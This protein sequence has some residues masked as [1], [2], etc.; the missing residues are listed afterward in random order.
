MTGLPMA[1]AV[2]YPSIN[3]KTN[4][5]FFISALVAIESGALIPLAAYIFVPP[6]QIHVGQ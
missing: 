3:L 1:F 5:N 4:L 6:L 2:S